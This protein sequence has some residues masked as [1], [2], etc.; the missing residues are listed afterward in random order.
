MSLS[1]F[2]RKRFNKGVTK[3]RVPLTKPSREMKTTRSFAA[4][5]F[6]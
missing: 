3:Q 2:D 1:V 6:E 5:E 4:F